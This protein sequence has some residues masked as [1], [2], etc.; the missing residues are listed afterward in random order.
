MAIGYTG[1]PAEITATAKKFYMHADT[2]KN[3]MGILEG[4]K[5]E[6]A[7]A[8]QG[9]TGTA[10]Q[11]AMQAA[12]DKGGKLHNVFMEIVDALNTAGAGFDSQDQE[13]ASQVNKYNLNF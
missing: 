6:Y 12:L 10:I 1:D 2:F 7:P 8:V 11:N 3:H 9:Q 5:L 4:I 13:G